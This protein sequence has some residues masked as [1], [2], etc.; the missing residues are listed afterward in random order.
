MQG[1]KEVLLAP[2]KGIE[3]GK[4]EKKKMELKENYFESM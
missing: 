2:K 4:K 1:C 3:W